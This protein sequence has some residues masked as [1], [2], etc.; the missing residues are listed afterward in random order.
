MAKVSAGHGMRRDRPEQSRQVVSTG[1][2]SQQLRRTLP[3]HYNG[4]YWD[5][6]VWK[7]RPSCPESGFVEGNHYNSKLIQFEKTFLSKLSPP[8]SHGLLG[9]TLAFSIIGYSRKLLIY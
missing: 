9:S 8:L 1:E 5:K 2:I 6:W 3:S 4:V 7:N